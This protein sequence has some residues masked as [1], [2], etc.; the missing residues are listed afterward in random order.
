MY[1]QAQELKAQGTHLMS[2]DEKTGIQALERAHPDLPM[3]PG[4]E[5]RTEFEYIRNGTQ[6]LTANFD[7][8]T[9]EIVSPTVGPTRNEEDFAAHIQRTIDTAPQAP[10]IFICDQLNT[11]KSESLVRLVASRC[12]IDEDLGVKGKSG[13]LESMG[14]RAEFLQNPDH[15]IR[16]VYTPKHTS[17]LNQVEIWFSILVRRLLKR[18]SFKSTE[19][20]RNRILSFIDYFNRTM[21]KPFKWTHAGRPLKA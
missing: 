19:E 1:K 11:H 18:A 17:W 13:I 4:L 16:F 3:K 7:V 8:A 5:K 2:T 12:G 10:W 6:C 15:R 14:S 20:L 9:G 21:A